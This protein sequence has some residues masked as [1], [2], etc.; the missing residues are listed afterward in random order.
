MLAFSMSASSL[1]TGE[2]F[3]VCP[4]IADKGMGTELESEPAEPSC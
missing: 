4:A 1:G 3:V 2:Y